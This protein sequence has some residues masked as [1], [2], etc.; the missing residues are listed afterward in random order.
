MGRLLRQRTVSLLGLLGACAVLPAAVVHFLGE[1]EVEISATVHFLP[2]AVSAGLAAAAAVALTVAGARRGDARSVVIGTA[3]SS[4]AALL[5]I[6]GLM[7]PGFV[8]GD[9]GSWRSRARRRCRSAAP[10]WR[11]QRFQSCG[12]RPR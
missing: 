2:I 4:M 7:T 3:F 1:T 6:H 8:V 9:N 5:S 11:W 12:A 10:C